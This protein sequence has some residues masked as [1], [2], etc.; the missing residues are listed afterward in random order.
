MQLELPEGQRVLAEALADTE[1]TSVTSGI[2]CAESLDAVT[3][4]A[5]DGMI[6][7]SDAEVKDGLVKPGGI[8]ALHHLQDSFVPS[9]KVGCDFLMAD[10]VLVTAV[11]PIGKVVDG[12]IVDPV[13]PTVAVLF[14]LT[15]D[16]G[17]LSTLIE[18]VIDELPKIL[19][20]A[21]D[22]T[23]STIHCWWFVF[24]WKIFTV[25]NR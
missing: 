15:D 8:S 17:V 1:Q 10:P 13:G 20:E 24:S 9:P 18:H 22:F 7:L 25:S 11:V 3:I 19:R 21:C 6:E 12:E 14:Q 16:A 5:G 2:L 23:G 4:E